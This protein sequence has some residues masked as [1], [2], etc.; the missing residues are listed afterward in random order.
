MTVFGKIKSLLDKA[1]ISYEVIEHEPVYT[2][3][4]AAHIRDTDVS[5]GAKALVMF[6]DKKPLLFVV[7]GDKKVD[8]KKVKREL[9]VKDLRMAKP[10]EVEELTTLKVGSIPPVGKSI[11]LNSYF[12]ESFLEKEKAVFNAGSLTTSIIMKASDLIKVENPGIIDM[13]S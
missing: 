13:V 3:A 7:P 8:F 1:N 6:A 9:A 4:D 11:G 5:Q 12:D 10:E 2:S